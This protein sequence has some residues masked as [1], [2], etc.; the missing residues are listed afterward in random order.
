MLSLDF[1][2][3]VTGGDDTIVRV[4]KVTKDFKNKSSPI[5]LTGATQAITGVDISK[6]STRVIASCKDANTYIFDL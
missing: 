2:C 6:D 1:T 4:Y 3:L 5:E